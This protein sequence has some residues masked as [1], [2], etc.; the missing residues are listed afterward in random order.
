MLFFNYIRTNKER[1]KGT[2]PRTKEENQEPKLKEGK[3]IMGITGECYN[4]LG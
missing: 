4:I 3:Y 2:K 1:E